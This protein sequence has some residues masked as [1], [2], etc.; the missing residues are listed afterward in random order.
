MAFKFNPFTGTFDIVESN[1]PV[2]DTS[3]GADFA[4]YD[5]L[6]LTNFYSNDDSLTAQRSLESDAADSYVYDYI[7]PVGAGSANYTQWTS[8]NH[9]ASV[10]YDSF[11][12]EHYAGVGDTW[13][14][15]LG[16]SVDGAGTTQRGFGLDAQLNATNTHI[17][18][19][20]NA[21]SAGTNESKSF[22]RGSDQALLGLTDARFDWKK[23]TTD[24][25]ALGG[26]GDLTAI[27]TITG[28]V[29]A[30]DATVDHKI[31]DSSD[32]LYIENTNSD[33]DIFIRANDGGTSWNPFGIDAANGQILLSP[34]PAASYGTT[35][36]LR[37]TD[38]MTISGTAGAMAFSPTVY[39]GSYW[40]V[41]LSQPKMRT[42][43][44][45]I[46][47]WLSPS[48]NHSSQSGVMTNGSPIITGLTDTSL[49]N[50][51]MR[52][53]DGTGAL[54][55]STAKVDSID[56]A[57]Q[58]T[59]TQNCTGTATN[60]IDFGWNHSVQMHRMVNG[61]FANGMNH[62]LEALYV[63][64]Q[65]SG[66]FAFGPSNDTNWR[67][68]WL[69]LGTEFSIGAFGG[70]IP[71][72]VDEIS[73]QIQGGV[74]RAIPGATS[75]KYARQ[76][77]IYLKGFGTQ[78]ANNIFGTEYTF[79]I[80]CDGGASW[81]RYDY[82]GFPAATAKN[83][84]FFGEGGGLTNYPDMGIGYD[85][86]DGIIDTGIINPSDLI[87]DCG[88]EKTVEL[89]ETVWEDLRVPMTATKG[90]GVRDPG[91][92]QFQD[93]GSGSTGVFT[94]MFSASTEEE[95]FFS[96]QF[97]HTKKNGT[98]IVPHV[99][100]SPTNTNTGT[101]RWGLEYTWA[102][103]NGNLGNTTI[104]YAEDA[105][106]GTA[107]DHLIAGFSAITGS[108]ITGVSSMIVC[109]IFRDAGHANDTYNADSAMLEVDFHFEVDTMGSRQ[110]TA[111]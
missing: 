21:A 75:G 11:F 15:I 86:T 98:D 12:N 88:T 74:S 45:A 104:I 59:L 27:G 73:I 78:G 41:F 42:G 89:Q 102:D 6:Y 33:S 68:T 52:A 22:V 108:G 58:V 32:D 14:G 47:F 17:E 31:Y 16:E 9:L 50:V 49:I 29:L 91:F 70:Y 81:F 25:M 23:G 53:Y 60:A 80:D 4:G 61:N 28:D 106:S 20:A 1:L 3:V 30:V 55:P 92:S 7:K 67:Y 109:R 103:I 37:C 35:G 43:A 8:T 66:A 84:V 10:S 82:T 93:D 94:Y 39:G 69:T 40:I 13:W 85:G 95:L 79:A 54:I 51:G 2:L 34:S 72:S 5:P 105:G 77:G 38:D 100:W 36:F 44:S 62:T 64:S 26:A 19:N 111:K 46:A 76:R 107:D 83:G 18:L 87:I 99:H 56:S 96:A 48:W 90:G 24:L 71:P 110:E 57:T 97:S 65:P 101:V 63:T